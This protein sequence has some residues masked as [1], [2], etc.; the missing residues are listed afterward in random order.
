M[1]FFV[2]LLMF[3]R[4]MP[5]ASDNVPILGNLVFFI[6]RAFGLRIRIKLYVICQ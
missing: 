2:L 6:A 3:E 1:A 5:P 4:N